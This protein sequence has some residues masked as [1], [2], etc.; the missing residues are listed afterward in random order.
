MKDLTVFYNDKPAYDI[1]YSNDF[2]L[3]ADK[4]KE[5]GY[6]LSDRK[7]ILSL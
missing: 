1:V 3:L 6:C 7:K 2:E 4:I 5:L